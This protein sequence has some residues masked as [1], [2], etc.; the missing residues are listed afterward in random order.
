MNTQNESASYFLSLESNL[1]KEVV[2][3]GD[4]NWQ[5]K[6]KQ[7]DLL[8]MLCK[9][10]LIFAKRDMDDTAANQCAGIENC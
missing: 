6:S 2:N 4:T 9:T 10:I 7:C 8:I 5:F 1:K 3:I